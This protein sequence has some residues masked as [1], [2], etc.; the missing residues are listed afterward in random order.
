MKQRINALKMRTLRESQGWSQEALAEISGLSPRSIQRFERG[1]RAA[2]ESLTRL[3]AVFQIEPNALQESVPVETQ[4]RRITPMTILPEIS[5]VVEYHKRNG[6]ELV[7]AGTECA[8][9]RYA[10]VPWIFVTVS[11]LKRH[12]LSETVRMLSGLTVP[13][14]YVRSLEAEIL[15]EGAEILD[16][17]ATGW[18][19]LEWIVNQ[20]GGMMFFAAR[21]P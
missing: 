2:A 11:L 17:A 16:Q 12:F 5:R 13:Y 3:A 7:S 4:F 8:G 1:S 14:I 10:G 15:A 6:A 18:G 21:G 20:H 9:I 19:T